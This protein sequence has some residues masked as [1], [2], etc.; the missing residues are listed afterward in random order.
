MRQMKLNFDKFHWTN[1]PASVAVSILLAGFFPTLSMAQQ[2]GQRRFPSAE[3]ASNALVEAAKSND[4]KALIKIFGQDGKQIVSSG[5]SVEDANTLANFV[6]RYQEMHR[7]MQEPDGT[8][9]LYIGAKNWPTPIPLVNKGAA[10][11]FDTEAGRKEILCRRIGQNETSTIRVCQE[12]MAAQK[13]Y[14]ASQNHEYAQAIFST[15]GKHNGLYWEVPEG[16]PQSPIG[17]LVA[18][19]VADG[20]GKGTKNTPTPYCGYYFRILQGQGNNIPGG[21][22]SYVANGKM[23]AGFAFVAFPA[24]YRSSGV[25]TF[26]VNQDGVVYQKD[27]GKITHTLAKTMTTYDPNSS[28]EKAEEVQQ[29]DATDQ[30]SK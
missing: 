9:T 19:A 29:A 27:C 15:K 2:P 18:S 11:Y 30:N 20:Y 1:L 22:K 28:W 10:W 4:E 21:A 8:T 7:L 13:E 17:P 16:A 24:E 23:T 3:D 6:E 14:Y 5:D 12:L 26:V 25:M